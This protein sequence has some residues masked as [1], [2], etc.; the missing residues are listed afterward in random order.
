MSWL[1]AS[2]RAHAE[3]ALFVALALG[4]GVA[5]IRVGAFHGSRLD[6]SR[7]MTAVGS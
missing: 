2:L 5:R 7:K 4:Y 3:L 1:A 6:R